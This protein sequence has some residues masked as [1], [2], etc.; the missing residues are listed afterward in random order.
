MVHLLR[1]LG[2]IFSDIFTVLN[3]TMC[4]SLFVRELAEAPKEHASV[5]YAALAPAP[6]EDRCTGSVS[7]TRCDGPLDLVSGGSVVGEP[8][9][10][11]CY[12]L[13]HEVR[14]AGEPRGLWACG[15]VLVGS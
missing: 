4:T 3:T 14:A 9:S 11:G 1:R 2:D 12:D 15:F 13:C 5:I 7:W 10:Q 8:V 6:G